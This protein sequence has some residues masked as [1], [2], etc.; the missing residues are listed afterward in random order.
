MRTARNTQELYE[1]IKLRLIP[2]LTVFF[3]IVFFSYLF[4]SVI[5]IVPEPISGDGATNE[6]ATT[7]DDSSFG[8]VDVFRTVFGF[9]KQSDSEG[10][11]IGV[12]ALEVRSGTSGVSEI[13]TNPGTNG[14][15]DNTP[16]RLIIDKLDRSVAVLNP[17][18]DTI[19]AMDAALLKGVVRH[20]DTADFVDTGNML[21]LGHSSYLPNVF[22]K[23]FQALNGL[24]NLTWGDIVRL[25]SA[26]TEYVYRVERVY[27]A[28]AT[29]LTIPNDRGE[30]RLTLATCN[31]FGA[32]EDRFVVEA[33]LVDTKAI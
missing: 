3:G 29:E 8:F 31:T 28:K 23:N 15:G 11:T 25:Q 27:Q 19:E 7:N 32:K 17:S 14:G 30:S 26:D 18:S 20:P 33:V 24:Q 4:L 16:D 6:S 1:Q 21:I 12:S 5:D 9:D 22:N 2:F 13:N 10:D